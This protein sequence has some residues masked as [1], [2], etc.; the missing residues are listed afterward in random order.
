MKNYFTTV[1]LIFFILS[2]C[3]NDDGVA[4]SDRNKALLGQWEYTAIT[5]DRAVD[6]NGD[7]VSNIDLF[8]TQELPQCVKDNITTYTENGPSNKPEYNVTE[9]NLACDDNNPFSFVE[10]DFWSL[11]NNNSVISFE[12]RE[13][14]RIVELTNTKLIVESDDTFESMEYVLTISFKRK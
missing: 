12:N 5:T 10:E 11:T 8:G 1:V 9:N 6:L 4:V 7:N 14:F 2:S 13:P 3:N